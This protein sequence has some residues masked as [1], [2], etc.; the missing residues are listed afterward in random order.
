MIALIA[1]AMIALGVGLLLSRKFGTGLVIVAC[2]ALPL[3]YAWALVVMARTSVEFR[4]AGA[5]Q[6]RGG[7]TRRR[8]AYAEA[9]R[10]QYF[11]IRQYVNAIYV[12]TTVTFKLRGPDGRSISWAGKYKEKPKGL[13]VTV[14]GKQFR[15][16]D[17]FDAVKLVVADAMLARWALSLE[18]GE[19][20]EWCA[21]HTLT[22]KGLRMKSGRR[23]GEVVP[24]ASI[25]RY[26][27]DGGW[28]SLWIRDEKK[29]FARVIISAPNFWPG[30]MLMA[31]M[32][33]AI[34]DAEWGR[35]D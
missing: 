8:I 14:F 35:R 19:E 4:Q 17:E 1:A 12:G 27:L 31:K 6:I 34:G 32:W 15:G 9:T 26:A 5:V 21:K 30:F 2:G 28:L 16:E 10:F 11:T 33:E 23:K 20:V 29:P 22:P 7:V 25:D 3:A 13:A 18:R 24:Y